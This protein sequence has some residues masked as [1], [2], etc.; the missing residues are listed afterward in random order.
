MATIQ[1]DRILQFRGEDLYDRDGD[2]IGSHRGDLPRRGDQRARV[3]ARP[4]RPVRHEADVRAR[5][6]T[7]AER[8]DNLSVPFEKS[9][10]KDA[11][12]I[13]ANGQLSQREEAELYRHYGLEYSE[14]RS[15]SGLA[16]GG[17]AP[18]TAIRAR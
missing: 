2:K 5:C 14:T 3:G 11:P 18:R 13:E 4:H 7:R 12:G 1:K 15:D 16:E 8:D 10:V 17:P 6:A 9:T